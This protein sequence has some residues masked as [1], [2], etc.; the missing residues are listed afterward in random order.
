LR[1]EFGN[2]Q[3]RFLGWCT[4]DETLRLAASANAI[5]VP[6][7]LEEAFGATTLEGLLLGKPTFALARGGTLE[8]HI[9]ASSPDQLRLHPD[10][11]SLV[12]DLVTFDARAGYAPA[13]DGLGGVDNAVRELLQIYRSPPRHSFC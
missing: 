12:T 8:Q 1:A 2:E 13:P 10:M 9:Y 6:S 4:P 3:I 5:V 7:L 11:R